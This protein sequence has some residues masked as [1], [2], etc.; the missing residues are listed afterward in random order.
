MASFMR[1]TIRGYNNPRLNPHADRSV[2]MKIHGRDRAAIEKERAELIAANEAATSWGAAIS[3]RSARIVE[4]DR[5]LA[6]KEW[7]PKP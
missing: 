7:R 3:A 2:P 6:I 1:R 4:I 5:A